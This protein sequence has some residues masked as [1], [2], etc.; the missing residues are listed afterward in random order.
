MTTQKVD[1]YQ[2]IYPPLTRTVSTP[3]SGVHYRLTQVAHLRDQLK[4]EFDTR[5]GLHKKYSRAV[6][7]VGSIDVGATATGGIL[8]GVGTGL[9]MTM[10]A[11]PAAAICMSVAAGCGLVST[12]TKVVTRRLRAKARKHDQIRILA[13]S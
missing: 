9:L 4:A 1:E 8:G 6:N 13:E 3:V 10:I 12:G 11:A 7:A 2:H 5:K